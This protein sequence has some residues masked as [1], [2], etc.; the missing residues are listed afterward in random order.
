MLLTLI[1]LTETIM[2]HFLPKNHDA[3]NANETVSNP[4][5]SLAHDLCLM[6][7]V[8]KS[9]KSTFRTDR[10]RKPSLVVI[11]DPDAP[12]CRY[13]TR[14]SPGTLP[15]IPRIDLRSPFK[16]HSHCRRSIQRS[17]HDINKPQLHAA[18]PSLLLAHKPASKKRHR[19]TTYAM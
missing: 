5:C 4:F 13:N 6:S 9:E 14:R 17:L 18:Q 10:N 19:L 11:P 7:P 12:F 8:W 15:A 16:M 3:L 1:S 2:K